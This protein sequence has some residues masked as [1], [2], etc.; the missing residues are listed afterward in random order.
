[1]NPQFEKSLVGMCPKDRKAV[2]AGLDEFGLGKD[3]RELAEM[4]FWELAVL[5]VKDDK[6]VVGIL[7]QPSPWNYSICLLAKHLN[8]I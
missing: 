8:G 7:Q 1:M 6:E 2:L 5:L 4:D 3:T